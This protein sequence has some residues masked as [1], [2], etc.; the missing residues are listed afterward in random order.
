[1]NDFAVMFYGTFLLLGIPDSSARFV[2]CPGQKT[3][4]SFVDNH[5]VVVSGFP[6]CSSTTFVVIVIRWP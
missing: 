5:A 4:T 6:L 1:M 2:S 3:W